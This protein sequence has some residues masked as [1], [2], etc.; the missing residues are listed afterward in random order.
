MKIEKITW[1]DIFSEA[2]RDYM[3]RIEEE[4]D[5]D[6]EMFESEQFTRY[7][8]KRSASPPPQP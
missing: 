1:A 2:H 4:Q 8:S 3:A 6:S 7:K 5:F